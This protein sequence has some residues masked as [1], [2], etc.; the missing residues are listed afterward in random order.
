[1]HVR[2][3]QEE[4]PLKDGFGSGKCRVQGKQIHAKCMFLLS[5]KSS[6]IDCRITKG[7]LGSDD[8]YAQKTNMD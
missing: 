3:L 5:L 7:D 2:G 1:M 4:R 6:E 8:E